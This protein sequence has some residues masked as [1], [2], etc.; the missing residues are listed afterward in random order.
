M[1]ENSVYFLLLFFTFRINIRGISSAFVQSENFRSGLENARDAKIPRKEN[2]RCEAWS[3]NWISMKRI[4]RRFDTK[5]YSDVSEKVY[6]TFLAD[7]SAVSLHNNCTR[8]K[9]S[10]I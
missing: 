10:Y 7:L 8:Q 6:A 9:E 3:W 2:R 1:F 4:A 5:I